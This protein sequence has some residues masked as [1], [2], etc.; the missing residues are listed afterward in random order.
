MLFVIAWLQKNVRY[1]ASTLG[2][3]N[4]G[5][6]QS[7]QVC[8][9]MNTSQYAWNHVAFSFDTINRSTGMLPAASQLL[10][11]EIESI[12]RGMRVNG[13]KVRLTVGLRFK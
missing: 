8:E 11:I 1:F 4:R 5:A 2:T 13:R 9:L 10:P 6:E 7:G 3:A 12:K